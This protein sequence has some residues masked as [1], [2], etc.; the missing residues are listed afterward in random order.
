[1]HKICGVTAR[2]FGG[3]LDL[4]SIARMWR[5]GCI[6]RSVFLNDIAA[7]FEAKR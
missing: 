5:G 1:M 4:A 7:A 6:I 2:A 3:K